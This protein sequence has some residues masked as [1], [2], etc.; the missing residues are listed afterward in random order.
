MRVGVLGTGSIGMRHLRVLGTVPGVQPV[1]IPTRESRLSELHDMGFEACMADDADV[2]ALI[3]A[4]DTGRHVAD[5][6]R[7][8][9][10]PLLIEKPIA[11]VVTPELL[12]LADRENVWVA[13]CLRHHP[14]ISHFRDAVLEQLPLTLNVQC[15]TYLPSWR[16]EQDY[17]QSYGARKGE[18]GA[19]RELIHE[20]DYVTW[21]MGFPSVVTG[22]ITPATDIEIADEQAATISCDHF[23]ITLELAQPGET[24]RGATA[25]YTWEQGSVQSARATSPRGRGRSHLSQSNADPRFRPGEG[26]GSSGY[27]LPSPLPE[28]EGAKDLPSPRGGGGFEGASAT[29]ETGAGTSTTPSP[30]PLPPG[31]GGEGGIGF[32]FVAGTVGSVAYRDIPRDLMYELQAKRFVEAARGGPAH[33]AL[34]TAREGIRALQ[35]CD[36]VRLSSETGQ[37]VTVNYV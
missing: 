37:P 16:P 30:S 21:I 14:I 11:G 20:I 32:D 33:P 3:I 18:G 17:R 19:L 22:A 25:Y 24:V 2:D 13:C 36:A 1:A 9:D 8:P 6:L 12:S 27:H 26:I 15:L 4:T 31:S 10:L 35:L 34:A 7:Y 5:A 23:D 29:E 28:G